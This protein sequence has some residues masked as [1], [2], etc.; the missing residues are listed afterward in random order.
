MLFS[1]Q[2]SFVVSIPQQVDTSIFVTKDVVL[3]L[4][5]Y[6]VDCTEAQ[7]VDGSHFAIRQRRVKQGGVLSFQVAERDRHYHMVC[8]EDMPVLAMNFGMLQ[9]LVPVDTFDV[10]IEEYAV[11]GYRA[12]KSVDDR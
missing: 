2:V 4:Q 11:F 5:E 9:S 3:K 1:V 10:M 8:S 6:F 12:G 7:L